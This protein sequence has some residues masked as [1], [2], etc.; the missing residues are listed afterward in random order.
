[1]DM[2]QFLIYLTSVLVVYCCVWYNN[3][4][5]FCCGFPAKSF[6]NPWNFLCDKECLCSAHEM[7]PGQPIESFWME[8]GTRKSSHMTRGLGHSAASGEGAGD[9]VQTHGQWFNQPCLCNETP[10]KPQDTEF[11]GIYWLVDILLCQEGDVPSFH[12]DR[13]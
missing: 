4:F 2:F 5:G 13:T 8:A 10:I 6:T 7:S 11:G 1:M 12:G 9:W 3:K